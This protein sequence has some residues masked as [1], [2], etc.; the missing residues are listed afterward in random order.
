MADSSLGTKFGR[1]QSGKSGW[2]GGWNR[3]GVQ[4][5]DVTVWYTIR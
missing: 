2:K 3:A 4:G 5:V 1:E